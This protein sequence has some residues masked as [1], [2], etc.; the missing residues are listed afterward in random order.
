[1]APCSLRRTGCLMKRLARDGVPDSAQSERGAPGRRV[2]RERTRRPAGHEEPA[3]RRW[4]LPMAR[5]PPARWAPCPD[6]SDVGVVLLD[7]AGRDTAAVAHLEALLLGPGPDR[8]SLLTVHC[9]ATATAGARPAGAAA[10]GRGADPTGGTDVVRQR[11]AQLLGVALGQVDL[12]AGAVEAESH[13]LAGLLA[14]EVV[15]EQH[16]NLLC[17]VVVLSLMRSGA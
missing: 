5:E 15:Q 14:G 11:V 2:R 6:R 13:G 4:R 10:A 7:D 3:Q 9:G 1:L 8:S 17:H 16:L 12:V